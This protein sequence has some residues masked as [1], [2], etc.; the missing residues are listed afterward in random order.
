MLKKDFAVSHNIAAEFVN[1][2][3]RRVKRMAGGITADEQSDDPDFALTFVLLILLYSRTLLMGGGGKTP[4]LSQLLCKIET[5]FQRLLPHFCRRP[6]Q[7]N[8]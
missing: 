1:K 2:R 7:W 5:Q 3:K 6:F 8:Y 4:A